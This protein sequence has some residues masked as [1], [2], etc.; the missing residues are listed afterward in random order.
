MR[1]GAALA[2]GPFLGCARMRSAARAAGRLR[3]AKMAQLKSRTRVR[4]V[5]CGRGTAAFSR[6]KKPLKNSIAFNNLVCA[7]SEHLG[8]L[9]LQYQHLLSCIYNLNF[10]H[11]V[12][13]F[14]IL[15]FIDRTCFPCTN[16]I[17]SQFFY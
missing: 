5:V 1:S 9:C 8:M 16:V 4:C 14:F 17:P 6:K 2:R 7:V 10:T 3:H 12:F 13:F 15:T 11:L